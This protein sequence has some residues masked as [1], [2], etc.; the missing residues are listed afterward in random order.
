MP[1]DLRFREFNSLKI[2]HHA[3]RLR[4]LAA[5][6]DIAPVTVEVDLVAYCN[7][8]CFWCVDPLHKPIKAERG[9]VE[10]LLKEL[11]A[12]SV[13]GFG[14]Q[15]IVFKGGGEP[16]LHP[17]FA[18][19]LRAARSFGFEIGVVTNG[20]RLLHP[21]VAEALAECAAY[22][23]VSIDGP[24]PQTH[25]R[26]HGT[27][28]FAH[29]VA[30]VER[31]MSL[32]RARHPI[33]GLSFAM[34]YAMLA[35]IPEAIA[36]GDRLGVDYALIRPP[37]FE[38]VGRS[39]TM[40]P[41]QAAELRQALAAAARAYTGSMD[42]LVG[43]WMGDAE[44][45]AGPDKNLDSSGRRDHQFKNDLPI[46]HRLGV[47]WAS[48]LLAVV[49][50]DGQVYGCCNLRFL[51]GWSFGRVDYAHGVTLADVWS[52]ALR[53][54]RLKS[55]HAA[56]CIAHCT[57]PMSRYNEIVEVLRDAEQPHSAFV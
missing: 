6:Q 40:T 57:H 34:D 42:V 22:V 38:E 8:R 41:A 10:Q 36:L 51:D 24:T 18:E 46:E 5:G 44:R 19:L 52:S 29:I 16:T 37:F 17:D 20:S 7:H 30:G 14:V 31:L 35:A 15:G 48:P 3:D 2:W 23:R 1:D 32:R 12:F 28:D 27:L 25:L 33:V 4:A 54:R 26:I 9:F 56:A 49:A 47:C 43:A 53:R 55:M 50:A 21:G 13:N 45:A 11:S 39:S